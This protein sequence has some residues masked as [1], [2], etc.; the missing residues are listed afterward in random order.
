MLEWLSTRSPAE[1]WWFFLAVN[2]LIVLASAGGN[3]WLRRR[4]ATRYTGRDQHTTRGDLLLVAGCIFLNAIVSTAGWWLWKNRLI[5]L[6]PSTLPA[7]ALTRVGFLLLM[8]LLMYLTHRMAHWPLFYR[9]FHHRHHQHVDTNPLSLF[10]LHPFE[11]IAFGSTLIA[12]IWIVQPTVEALGLYLFL[13]ILFGSLGHADADLLPNAWTR[14]RWLG[15]TGLGK[16]HADH[17]EHEHA[18]FG[19][20]TTLWDRIARTRHQ[21]TNTGN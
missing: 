21:P 1:I 20:Y 4:A 12:V 17:H 10:V 7:T 6:R 18:N 15:W 14:S 2:L 11:V 16:F 9:W 8:D 13:N 19:F 3:L 5:H